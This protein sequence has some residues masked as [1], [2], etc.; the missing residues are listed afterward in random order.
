ME[1]VPLILF[2]LKF[3]VQIQNVHIM[4]NYSKTQIDELR[5]SFS[6]YYFLNSS[7]TFARYFMLISDCSKV[8]PVEP[9][10]IIH[11]ALPKC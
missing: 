11:A 10:S 1:N 6:F 7:K 9:T 4:K 5:G 3:Y 2:L 8:F